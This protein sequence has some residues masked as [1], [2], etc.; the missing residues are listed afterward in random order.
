MPLA[1]T[2]RQRV[3]EE[4]VLSVSDEEI[5]ALSDDD[6][7]SVIL[8]C[9]ATTLMRLPPREQEFFEWLR[10]RDPLVWN[11]LWADDPDMLVSIHFLKE[12]RTA[13]RGFVICELEHQPNF[14]F[15]ERH[16]KPEGLEALS[17]IMA[18]I[19]RGEDLAAGEVL[20]FEIIR[21]P[22]DIWHFCYKYSVPIESGKRAVESLVEHG[23]LVHLPLREDLIPYLQG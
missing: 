18:K 1:D 5:L 8:A 11:D 6:V 17:V 16:L 9:D 21:A 15:T 4:G 19:E 22:I 10:E 7:D 13:D 14:Y 3:E 12:L 2:F 20:L 23:F